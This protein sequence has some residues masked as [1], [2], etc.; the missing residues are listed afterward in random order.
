MSPWEFEV[1]SADGRVACEREVGGI[2]EGVEPSES[3]V[4]ERPEED[5]REVPEDEG[6]DREQARCLERL[7]MRPAELPGASADASMSSERAGQ[8]HVRARNICTTSCM[9]TDAARTVIPP[10]QFS[11]I[12]ITSTEPDAAAAARPSRGGS[13]ASPRVPAPRRS[14]PSSLRPA[15]G[16]IPWTTTA[17]QA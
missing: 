6:E 10:A 7:K 12:A 4:Q 3:Q 2:R 15:P 17:L 1:R 8:E 13:L 11:R 14:A 16:A 5:L 9:N